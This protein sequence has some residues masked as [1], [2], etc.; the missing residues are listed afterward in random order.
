MDALFLRG[1][2]GRGFGTAELTKTLIKKDETRSGRCYDALESLIGDLEGQTH[3]GALTV[4]ASLSYADLRGAADKWR[5]NH[6]RLD[7]WMQGMDDHP[8]FKATARPD[9]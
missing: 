9:S 7:A 5:E 6:P 3:M 1:G 4:A 2:H 8:S